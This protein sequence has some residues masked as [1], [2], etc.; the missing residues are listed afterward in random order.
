VTEA[1]L[2][3]VRHAPVAVEGVCYGQSDVP[4]RVDAREATDAIL[5]QLVRL[6]HLPRIDRIWTSPWRR[7]RDIAALLAERL[8]LPL[9]V[10]PRLS[11]LSFGVWEGRP[12][13]D[14]EIS[15]GARFTRWMTR[16]RDE[17]APGG[18]RLADLLERI[19]AWHGDVRSTGGSALAVTH[20]GPIRA[21]RAAARG[22]G[23]EVALRDPVAHLHVEPV[24]A[25][26]APSHACR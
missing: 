24:G 20:A 22:V 17:A 9:T 5:A 10:D 1:S 21:L 8:A 15:D 25:G 6:D 4:V 23:Y 7:T 19:D 14:L 12:Y 18:E 16:W 26:V 3:V 11:E 13:R 2:C